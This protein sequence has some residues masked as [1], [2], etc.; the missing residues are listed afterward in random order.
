MINVFINGKLLL[1]TVINFINGKYF[2]TVNNFTKNK[3]YSLASLYKDDIAVY[4]CDH[5]FLNFVRC[6]LESTR[7]K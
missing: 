7:I 1:W 6:I 3:W 4:N 5:S 2:L